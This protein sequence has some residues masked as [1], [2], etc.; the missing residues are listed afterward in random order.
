MNPVQSLLNKLERDDM[1]LE[2]EVSFP[3]LGENVLLTIALEDDQPSPYQVDTLKWF[4]DSIKCLL[5]EI[6]QAIYE[7]YIKVQP[8]YHIGLGELSEELMPTL[9]NK[10]EI[11]NHITEP[12]IFIFPES[13]GGELHLE[14]ECSF[15]TENGLRVK[16]NNRKLIG[17]GIQ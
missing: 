3:A 11:W 14:Y 13:E 15:D 16:F 8:D 9:S 2:G 1:D 4:F 12:G 10:N 7:Y 17:V 6:E 5:P